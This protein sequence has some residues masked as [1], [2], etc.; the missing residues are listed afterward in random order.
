[1][2][3][4]LIAF[5]SVYS[6]LHA[7]CY[8]RVKVLLPEKWPAHVLLILFFALMV[9]APITTRLLERGGQDVLARISAVLGL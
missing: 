4:F 8:F 2:T 1:M 3:G 7:F 5:F 9:F 6:L